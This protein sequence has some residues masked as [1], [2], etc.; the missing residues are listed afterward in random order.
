MHYNTCIYLEFTGYPVHTMLNRSRHL[1]THWMLVLLIL[2]GPWLSLWIT[3][4]LVKTEGGQQIF[5]C[6]LQGIKAVNISDITANPLQVS[7]QQQSSCPA[8]Q[9]FAMLGQGLVSIPASISLPAL[10]PYRLHFVHL[11]TPSLPRLRAYPA[12]APPAT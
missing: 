4:H 1:L 11:V 5:L 8:L 9:L 10:S 2:M 6:T 3:P 12:R 7:D